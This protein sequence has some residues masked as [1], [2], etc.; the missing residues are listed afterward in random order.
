MNA[1][2]EGCARMNWPVPSLLLQARRATQCSVK[3]IRWLR[4]SI[5]NEGKSAHGQTITP[6][7][8][9]PQPLFAPPGSKFAYWDSAQNQ[10]SHV[11]T[12]IAEEPIADLF[13][14]RIPD[15][16]GMAPGKWAWGDFGERGG[17]LING[18]A[19][20]KGKGVSIS[21]RTTG[22]KHCRAIRAC[23]RSARRRSGRSASNT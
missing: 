2:K 23:C 19:G 7:D 10:F 3:F 20:N 21:A 12:R 6:F 1:L 4:Q 16:I 15:P 13:R 14:R 11:L 18:G 5:R 17:P 9:S 22:R 8:P